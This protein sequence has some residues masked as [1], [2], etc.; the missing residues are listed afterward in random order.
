V[1][2]IHCNISSRPAK[3]HIV[4]HHNVSIGFGP[5]FAGCPRLFDLI[6][7]K[8]AKVRPAFFYACGNTLVAKDLEQASRI[9][10]GHDRRFRRVVTQKVPGI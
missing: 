7:V 3:R 10:Y 4:H 8:D 6:K 2:A 9:A 5:N 1:A